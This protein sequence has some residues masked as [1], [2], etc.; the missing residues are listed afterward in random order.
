LIGVISDIS[1]IKY[2]FVSVAQISNTSLGGSVIK[3][4]AWGK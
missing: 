3:Y 1:V 2:D 4:V